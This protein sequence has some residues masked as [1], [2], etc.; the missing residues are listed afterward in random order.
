M[1]VIWLFSVF[2]WLQLQDNGWDLLSTSEVVRTP[3]PLSGLESESLKFSEG[4]KELEGSTIQLSGYVIPLESQISYKYFILSRYPYQSC[5]FCGA[6]GP[7]TVIEVYAKAKA[8]E[9]GMDKRITVRGKLVLN[10]KDPL[11]LFYML[12]DAEVIP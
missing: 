12:E 6:A 4:V 10:Q 8:S 11:H 2:F 7:E 5:F 3:D 9:L 1:K